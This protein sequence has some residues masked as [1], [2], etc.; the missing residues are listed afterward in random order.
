[1]NEFH[2][3]KKKWHILKDKKVC[4]TPIFDL[5]EKTVTP[6]TNQDAGLFYVLEAPEWINVLPITSDNEIVLVEQYRHGVEEVTLE[7]PGG[8]VDPGEKPIEA[9]NRELLEETGYISEDWEFLG[10]ASSNP[11]FMTNYTHLFLAKNCV[12]DA[13]PNTDRF[14]DIAVHRLPLDKFLNFVKK[15]VIHHS[16]V[17]AAVAKYLVVYRD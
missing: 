13:E 9:A 11:A 4:G 8:M 1:M 5:I 6:G 14:E 3:R 10:K 7:I 2:P 16:I 12:Q 15:G 17:L